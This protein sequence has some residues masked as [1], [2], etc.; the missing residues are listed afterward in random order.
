MQDLVRAFLVATRPGL[1]ADEAAQDSGASA[2]QRM[3]VYDTTLALIC[4]QQPPLT[5]VQ[6]E[7]LISALTDDLE[8]ATS[9]TDII[10]IIDTALAGFEGDGP[11]SW[12]A[13]NIVPKALS[14]IQGI[15]GHV[16]LH[17][18]ASDYNQGVMRRICQHT[19]P[20][21]SLS[22]ILLALRDLPL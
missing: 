6:A 5:D 2:T 14:M 1:I 19:W 4:S 7:H 20:A 10:E 12:T 11:L 15:D 22:R 9:P 16:D 13:L 17:S 21:G 8:H 3:E 18:N